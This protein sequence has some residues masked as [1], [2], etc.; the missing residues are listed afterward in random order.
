MSGFERSSPALPRF[1]ANLQHHRAASDRPA[2]W[3]RE[4]LAATAAIRSWSEGPPDFY[5]TSLSP[6]AQDTAAFASAGHFVTIV[7][8]PMLARQRDEQGDASEYT[9]R[10]STRIETSSHGLSG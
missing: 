8:E 1:V 6:E 7:D 5:V 4:P 10:T 9:F 2:V 3:A